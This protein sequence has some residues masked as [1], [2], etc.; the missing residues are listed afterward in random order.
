MRKKSHNFYDII[1][2]STVII[3]AVICLPWGVPEIIA[4]TWSEKIFGKDI[5][6]EESD[7]ANREMPPTYWIICGLLGWFVLFAASNYLWRIRHHV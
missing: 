3:V 6:W 4:R 2:L 7:V 5:L 1:M